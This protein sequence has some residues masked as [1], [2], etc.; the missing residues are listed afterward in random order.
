MLSQQVR[1]D[2]LS[3]GGVIFECGLVP[4]VGHQASNALVDH[5]PDPDQQHAGVAEPWAEEED[6]VEK[7]LHGVVGV[8]DQGEEPARGDRVLGGVGGQ[9]PQH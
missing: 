9:N 4:G 2:G 7:N 6:S 8:G 3:C 1:Y 5:H